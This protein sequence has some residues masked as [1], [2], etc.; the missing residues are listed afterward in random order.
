MV[1]KTTK[2]EL[3][4]WPR[5]KLGKWPKQ[6]QETSSTVC[7]NSFYLSNTLKGKTA[8]ELSVSQL[9]L[10]QASYLPFP[11]SAY[12]KRSHT[13][14][15]WT[16]LPLSKALPPGRRWEGPS[17]GGADGLHEVEEVSLKAHK[18]F[19]IGV[20]WK[21]KLYSVK[22]STAKYY[23]WGKNKENEHR[24]ILPS[25]NKQTLGRNIPRRA[26]RAKLLWPGS[27]CQHSG[28]INIEL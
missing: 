3:W 16:P 26:A 7:A 24:T 21:S 17:R 14:P 27:T 5:L 28:G 15:C 18:D 19:Y 8:K 6:N 20:P 1:R 13:K 10:N 4:N 12:V 25:P 2:E 23:T 22:V 9:P 11:E